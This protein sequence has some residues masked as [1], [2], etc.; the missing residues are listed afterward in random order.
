M[1]GKG[2]SDHGRRQQ[3]GGMG[4][5]ALHT[6]Q[7]LMMGGI[8]RTAEG[9]LKSQSICRAM[10]LEDQTPLPQQS[11]PI[12]APVVNQMFKAG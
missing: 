8:I 12:V 4:Q 10:A 1:S 3:W 2:L 6:R 9:H 7:Q 11:R 5:T